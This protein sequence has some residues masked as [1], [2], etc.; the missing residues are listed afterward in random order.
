MSTSRKLMVELDTHPRH[1]PKHRC[2]ARKA[3]STETTQ[4]DPEPKQTKLSTAE[5]P[6]M[7]Q[8]R[9]VTACA[10]EQVLLKILLFACQIPPLKFGLVFN[11]RRS[12]AKKRK[13]K[14][15]HQPDSEPKSFLESD[16]S[17]TME[18]LNSEGEDERDFIFLHYPSDELISSDSIES[19]PENAENLS[20]YWSEKVTGVDTLLHRDHVGPKN[21]QDN[22]NNQGTALS[23]LELF[24]NAEFW[25]PLCHQTNLPAEQAKQSKPASYYALNFKL[26]TSPS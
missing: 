3:T 17:I 26:L 12:S 15:R 2:T 25:R 23:F 9:T 20:T 5:T 18:A 10:T 6:A 8:R 7:N 16:T 4:D 21:I 14:G 24:L 22:I 1:S 19:E 13:P 11:P